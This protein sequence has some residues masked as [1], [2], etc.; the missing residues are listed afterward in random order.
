VVFEK[1][2]PSANLSPYAGFQFFGQ[3]DID[4]GSGE[5]TVSLKDINGE[6][7]FSQKLRPSDPDR[8]R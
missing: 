7:V 4:D 1:A 6:T 8:R 5:M 3:V 2:P